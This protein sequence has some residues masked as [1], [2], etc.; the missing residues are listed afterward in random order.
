MVYLLP[1]VQLVLL[2]EIQNEIGEKFECVIILM[3][4]ELI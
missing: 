3:M 1:N 4:N 2:R